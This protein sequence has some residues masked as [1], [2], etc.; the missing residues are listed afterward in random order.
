MEVIQVEGGHR[1]TGEVRVEGAKNSALKL[2]AATIM[3][4]GVTTPLSLTRAALSSVTTGSSGA[5][6]KRMRTMC[7]LND[8]PR[9]LP[10]LSF[11]FRIRSK[12]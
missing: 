8:A 6:F 12:P 2:M 4:P 10:S 9:S 11:R 1:F 7:S 3:A 5:S